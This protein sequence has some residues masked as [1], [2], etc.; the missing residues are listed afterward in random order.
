MPRNNPPDADLD[1]IGQIARSAQRLAVV[2][3]LRSN[4]DGYL[5]AIQEGTG[6]PGPSLAP[7]LRELEAQGII[8][9]DLPAT[10]RRGRTVRYHL[11]S[12]R[13]TELLEHL[14]A[15]LLA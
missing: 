13:L 15:Q 12:D 10:Q 4:P 2:R 14:R 1:A 5:G 11:D 8:R 6:I 7:H 3:Y 9:G